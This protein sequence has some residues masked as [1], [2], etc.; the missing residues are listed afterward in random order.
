MAG[1]SNREIVERYVDAI[2]RN[3]LEEMD[4]LVSDDVVEEY[5]QS[6]EIIRGKANQKAIMD[7]YPGRQQNEF[8]AA[9]PEISGSG[10]EFTARGPLTYPNGETW[11]IVS[12]VSLRNGKIAKLT[13][14]FA[15][16]F[17]APAWR[18]KWVEKKAA[19]PVG[20]GR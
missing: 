11:H 10:D 12:L 8:K 7:N 15:Q 18:A 16:P 17:E 4:A 5:P 1:Q 13:T 2:S 9:R 14:Y 3:A 19:E 6:G 20:V